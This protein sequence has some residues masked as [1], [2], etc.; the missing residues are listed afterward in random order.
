M[1]I[2][3][4]CEAFIQFLDDHVSIGLLSNYNAAE[5]VCKL[6]VIGFTCIASLYGDYV[7]VSCHGGAASAA[8]PRVISIALLTVC[9]SSKQNIRA[10]EIL[11]RAML[12]LSVV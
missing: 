2:C 10:D 7:P 12:S 6:L 11:H 3:H 4:F 1:A 5:E 9:D 8:G